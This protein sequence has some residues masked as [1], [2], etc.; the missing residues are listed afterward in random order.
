MDDRFE[1][2]AANNGNSRPA[3]QLGTVGV[4]YRSGREK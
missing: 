1:H 4:G 3:G 2:E